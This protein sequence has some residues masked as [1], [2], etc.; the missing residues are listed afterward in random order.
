[1]YCGHFGAL[2]I[3][4]RVVSRPPFVPLETSLVDSL[5]GFGQSTYYPYSSSNAAIFFSSCLYRISHVPHICSRTHG[6]K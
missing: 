4:I 3:L 5:S 2:R 1:M 6:S